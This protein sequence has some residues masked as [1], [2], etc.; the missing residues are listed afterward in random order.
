MTNVKWKMWEIPCLSRMIIFPFQ[1]YPGTGRGAGQILLQS[2]LHC[3]LKKYSIDIYVYF[4]CLLFRKWIGSRS[5]WIL[6][7]FAKSCCFISIWAMTC[8]NQQSKCA[9]SEDSGQPRHPPSLIRVFAV[10]MK[11][12]WALSYP[13]SAQRRLWSDWA[14]AEADLSLPWAHSHFVDF[15]MLRLI[16]CRTTDCKSLNTIIVNFYK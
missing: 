15:V 9:P 11:K 14:D 2:L 5:E 3:E 16:F 12:P 7:I 8:Q 10:R 6:T 1:P 13:L 4:C